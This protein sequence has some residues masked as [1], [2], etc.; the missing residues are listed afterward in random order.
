MIS[1]SS[2]EQIDSDNRIFNNIEEDDKTKNIKDL[3]SFESISKDQEDFF[4]L[5]IKSYD[6]LWDKKNLSV[7][8][9]NANDQNDGKLITQEIVT[10]EFSKVGFNFT[11]WKTCDNRGANIRILVGDNLWPGVDTFGKNLHNRKDGVKLTFTFGQAGPTSWA[12]RCKV[13]PNYMDNCIRSYALHEFGHVIGLAHE[14]SRLDSRCSQTTGD[15]V[16]SIGDYDEN[17][18]MNYCN[19]MSQIQNN[20]YP[21]L[22][23]G[24]IAEINKLYS[25]ETSNQVTGQDEVTVSQD[26]H[27]TGS[28]RG[29]V[30]TSESLSCPANGDNSGIQSVESFDFSNGSV[31]VQLS[32]D[33]SFTNHSQYFA[34]EGPGGSLYLRF[35]RWG[36]NYQLKAGHNSADLVHK[37]YSSMN[38]KYLKISHQAAYNS[39][40]FSTSPDGI[41]WT[42]FGHR[43]FSGTSN[44]KLVYECGHT[45]S[46]IQD[47]KVNNVVKRIK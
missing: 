29:L 9:E 15:S 28:G 46:Y 44:M 45:A 34:I 14:A 8:W 32:L 27:L 40:T 17:S 22:S 21:M 20:E 11:G 42:P 7:C 10:S 38:D 23:D 47:V 16:I 33:T 18:I 43:T 5:A 30:T 39:V 26:F 12:Y 25:P 1:C 36:N 24:D 4:D 41:N 3:Q 35:F 37:T 31:T 13:S 2:Q 6:F 19:N